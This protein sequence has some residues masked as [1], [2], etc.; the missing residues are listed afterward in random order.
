MSILTSNANSIE[1]KVDTSFWWWFNIFERFS[2]CLEVCE[3]YLF[4]GFRTLRWV[5]VAQLRLDC[6][7]KYA[8]VFFLYIYY[9]VCFCLDLALALV[10]ARVKFGQLLWTYIHLWRTRR[11]LLRLAPPTTRA[12]LLTTDIRLKTVI[13]VFC[14]SAR[15]RAQ[16]LWLAQLAVKYT[17]LLFHFC[18]QLSLRCF[19]FWVDLNFLDFDELLDART[20]SCWLGLC[21]RTVAFW[22]LGD[23]R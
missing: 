16:I 20:V 6:T 3:L 19:F 15:L 8:W 14:Q 13:V 22:S 11:V 9:I 5:V 18:E 10:I 7:P 17:Y 4:G 12:L 23:V 1:A 2:L 21:A